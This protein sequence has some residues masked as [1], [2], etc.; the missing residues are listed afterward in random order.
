MRGT[1]DHP[2]PRPTLLRRRPYPHAC[3]PAG[4][5]SSSSTAAAAAAAGAKTTN[6]AAAAAALPRGAQPGNHKHSF[7]ATATHKCKPT[8]A[9]MHKYR[10]EGMVLLGCADVATGNGP[11]ATDAQ[12]GAARALVK[13]AAAD[14]VAVLTTYALDLTTRHLYAL[15]VVLPSSA[16]AF[17][18]VI[19][20][21]SSPGSHDYAPTST[22]NSTTTT[23]TTTNTANLGGRRSLSQTIID[24]RYQIT[25]T[26]RPSIYA[27]M[28]LLR[29]DSAVATGL[30][31][32]ATLF[33]PDD[34]LTKASCLVSSGSGTTYTNF[35]FTPAKNGATDPYGV[36]SGIRTVYWG[37]FVGA[38]YS[39]ST[40]TNTVYAGSA[41]LDIG[42]VTLSTPATSWASLAAPCSVPSGT[43]VIPA[44]ACGY[45]GDKGTTPWC[46]DADTYSISL[47]DTLYD[48]IECPR[49]FFAAGEH[50]GPLFDRNTNN[51]VGVA[52]GIQL[53]NYNH[54][55]R[56]AAL[57]PPRASCL[58]DS[59]CAVL[60]CGCRSDY[61]CMYGGGAISVQL[62]S[63]TLYV[64]H[65]GSPRQRLR[66]EVA[67]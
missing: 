39:A 22:D 17:D 53:N 11:S 60:C 44:R 51:I 1:S 38:T 37:I 49:C 29:Y 36:F 2:P 20:L 26:L 19:T 48:H 32:S 9:D 40:G 3:P 63:C 66:A 14:A 46:A 4:S 21:T 34:I 18:A 33:S 52:S 56:P 58:V 16:A 31:C 42:M 65:A 8:R 35:Q 15:P 27:S 13:G 54:C 7:R 47:C 50:G 5:S 57:H 28:G 64:H 12:P 6:T 55:E 59:C 67:P 43:A 10:H 41:F 61:S 23:N 45:P 25:S 24:N 62:A 30:R